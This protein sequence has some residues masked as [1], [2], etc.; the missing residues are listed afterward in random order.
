[1]LRLNG[2]SLLFDAHVVDSAA[3]DSKPAVTEAESSL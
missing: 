3:T 2:V 1:V